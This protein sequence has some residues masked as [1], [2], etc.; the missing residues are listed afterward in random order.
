MANEKRK[1]FED[2]SITGYME[3]PVIT[4]EPQNKQVIIGDKLILQ[5]GAAGIPTPSYQWYH[6]GHAIAGSCGNR[7]MILKTRQEHS[8]QYHCVVKNFLSKV[9]SK[10]VTVSFIADRDF[11]LRI[12]PAIVE[13]MEGTTCKFTIKSPELA[14]LAGYTFQW[15]LNEKVIPGAIQPKLK[16]IDVKSFFS[17]EYRLTIKKQ[18]DIR[19]S[20]VARLVVKAKSNAA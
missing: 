18:D 7:L 20:N 5:I 12:E 10:M 11:D 4:R 2:T 13:C 15:Y 3:C 19:C 6:N 17:G 14:L 9:V 8:G 16:F 1:R